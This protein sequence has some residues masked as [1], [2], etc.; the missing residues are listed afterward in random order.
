MSLEDFEVEVVSATEHINRLVASGL[1]DHGPE[2]A[3]AW[4]SYSFDWSDTD[5][6]YVIYPTETID[7]LL[8]GAK[9]KRDVFDLAIFVAGTR[10]AAGS[11]L[12]PKLRE[13]AS[14]YLIGRIIP[15]RIP[16]GRPTKST[17]GRDFILIDI[18]HYL[19]QSTPLPMSQ[20]PE[21]KT[22]RVHS[23]TCSEIVEEAVKRSNLPNS[24]R[25]QIE[26]IW[27]REKARDEHMNLIMLRDFALL[28]EANDIDRR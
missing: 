28:D 23:V 10:L 6:S 9:E 22:E 17:W 3:K 11:D 1:Y 5:P 8:Q 13:F 2:W 7:R 26:K 14:G 27:A 19:R 15:P 24:S 12:D 16:S 4:Y 20:N 21:R 18:M 25:V